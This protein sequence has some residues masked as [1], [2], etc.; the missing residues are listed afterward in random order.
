[1]PEP[2]DPPSGADD[3]LLDALHEALV[4]DA[5]L[6][7][8]GVSAEA[9]DSAIAA[10]GESPLATS[11]LA[12]ATP[13][14]E[15]TGPRA[16]HAKPADPAR[17]IATP[18]SRPAPRAEDFAFGEAGDECPGE[19]KGDP[20]QAALRPLRVSSATPQRFGSEALVL[21]LEGRGRAKLAYAK[22]D[23][24]AAA[25]VKRMSES[26]KPVLL[27]DLVIGSATG[28]GELRVVRLRADGF[29]P[30][31]LVPGHTS[32]LVALRAFV[33][34]LRARTRATA[35]P[36]PGEPSAPFRIYPDLA[37]YER[38]VLG[39]APR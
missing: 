38:E 17:L 20:A 16:L 12:E 24:V 28:A 14:G 34:E 5:E 31:R 35:L 25:G 22:V 6:A 7:R 4:G 21:Q 36:A 32:P 10:A 27:I 23:A 19:E 3:A 8:E 18:P 37:T 1:V 2:Q 29:D 26:G 9:A 33:A 11:A 39:A 30:R 13:P 15:A